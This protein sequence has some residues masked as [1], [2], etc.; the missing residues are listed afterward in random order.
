MKKA[1]L[2]VMAV[3]VAVMFASVAMAAEST[4]MSSPCTKCGKP[5]CTT[6]AKPCNTCVKPCNTCTTPCMSLPKVKVNWAW[7]KMTVE[8]CAPCQAPCA[9]PCDTFKRDVLGNKVPCQTYEPGNANSDKATGYENTLI[10]C[11]NCM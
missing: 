1:A 6:C 8:P 10:S 4:S 11:Q 9:K 2:M 7:P 5:A 3:A